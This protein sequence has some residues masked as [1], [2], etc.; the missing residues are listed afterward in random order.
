MNCTEQRLAGSGAAVLWL[1]CRGTLVAVL[2]YSGCGAAVLWLR[3]RG[4]LVAVP[5]YSGC[6]AAVLWPRCRGTLAAV[7]RASAKIASLRLSNFGKPHVSR[8]RYITFPLNQ[9][10]GF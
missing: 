9:A 2:R 6:G 8:R 10:H 1:R 4:T 5:R 7:P 3:C